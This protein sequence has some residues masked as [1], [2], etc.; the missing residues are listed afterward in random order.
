MTVPECDGGCDCLDFDD[1]PPRLNHL[2]DK[3]KEYEA[4][5]KACAEKTDEPPSEF[6]KE[7]MDLVDAL[8]TKKE[9]VSDTIPSHDVYI[10]EKRHYEYVD[11]PDEFILILDGCACMNVS[12]EIFDRLKAGDTLKG[13]YILP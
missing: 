7:C 13:V 12:K 1:R 9:K 5:I 4:A 11:K 2:I 10:K 6:D 3:L 8:T